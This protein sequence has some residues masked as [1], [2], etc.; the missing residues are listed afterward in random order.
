MAVT[1]AMA[2]ACSPLPHC[3]FL[4]G[5]DGTHVT[6]RV[7]ARQD[8]EMLAQHAGAAT[9]ARAARAERTFRAPVFYGLI[10]AGKSAPALSVRI[11]RAFAFPTSP[12]GGGA[13]TQTRVKQ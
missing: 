3:V 9:S 11:V 4:A 12:A 13:E 1:Q 5:L 2:M 6:S 7:P 10:A 8:A